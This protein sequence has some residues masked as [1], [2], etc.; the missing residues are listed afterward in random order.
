MSKSNDIKSISVTRKM[1]STETWV[2]PLDKDNKEHYFHL[3][4]NLK[5]LRMTLEDLFYDI[6]EAEGSISDEKITNEKFTM[7]LNREDC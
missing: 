3:V 1:T 2:L 7:H 5:H 6:G 4:S